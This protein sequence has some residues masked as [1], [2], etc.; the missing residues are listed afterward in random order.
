MGKLSDLI[1][2]TSSAL[3]AAKFFRSAFSSTE[4]SISRLEA[5]R[6]V[7]CPGSSDDMPCTYFADAGSIENRAKLLIKH[8][9][10]SSLD[11]RVQQMAVRAVSKKCDGDHWCVA[12]KDS[13]GEIAA[14]L[15]DAMDSRSEIAKNIRTM[16]GLFA[17]NREQVRYVS[18]HRG[19]DLFRGAFRTMGD[20]HGGDCDCSANA[21]ASMAR[22]IGFETGVR[23]Y[24]TKDSPAPNHVAA[25]VNVAK[26]GNPRWM[27]LD[28]TVEKVRA[29]GR[30]SLPYAGW[31]APSSILAEKRDFYVD[32]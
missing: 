12:P 21:L 28:P 24:R 30:T 8:I 17:H 5:K 13:F 10:E 26:R 11:P 27:V 22:A 3:I 31:E 1:I 15:K 32:G 19:V 23:I 6:G 2:G 25:I 4:A 16:E 18:D 9:K 29:G 20:L 7:P 14:L